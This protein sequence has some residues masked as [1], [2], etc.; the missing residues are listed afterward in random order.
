MVDIN[1]SGVRWHKNKQPLTGLHEH[2]YNMTTS[3]FESNDEK[4][5]WKALLFP[6]SIPH[7]GNLIWADRDKNWM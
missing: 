2:Y 6:N 3:G 1:E 4:N 7:H 5:C